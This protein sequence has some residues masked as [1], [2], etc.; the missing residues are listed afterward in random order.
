[1]PEHFGKTHFCAR[2][3]ENIP[4]YNTAN[5][6]HKNMHVH[7]I[8]IGGS[9][10]H[11]L[12]IA[13]KN[14]GVHVTGSDDAIFE[15]SATRL[16]NAD[17]LPAQMGW[18]PDKISETTS[19][20]IL[21]MHARADNPEL[22]KANEL[23]VRVYSFPEYFYENTKNKIRIVVA[24]SHGK[25]STTA[26]LMHVFNHAGKKFDYLVGSKVDGFDHMVSLSPDSEYAIIEGDEYLT[27]P[28]DRRP[29]FV[30]YRANIG[31]LNGIAWDHIN[32][33]PTWDEYLQV[34]KDFIETIALGGRLFYFKNDANID[35]VLSKVKCLCLP[36][37]YSAFPN[38]INNGVT[39]LLAGEK[40][41]PLRVFGE[42]NMQNMAATKKVCDSVGIPEILFYTAMESFSG[43]GRR[44]ELIRSTPHTSIFYDFAHSPSKLKATVS[45]VKKQF[46]DR[47]LVALFELHTFSSLNADFLK[48]YEGTLDDADVA[49]VYFNPDEIAHK[50]LTQF[51]EADVLSAF[52]NK[53]LLVFTQA[54]AWQKHIHMLSLEDVSLLLMSSGSF[55]GINIRDFASSL[56]VV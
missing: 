39:Y 35:S 42:H 14:S 32:V 38:V 47:K 18:F 43:A 44:L 46:A 50:K 24:G 56:Q 12:A 1:M 25:T 21:G 9:I 45:A 5:I 4:K 55:G 2:F 31:I 30:H 36:E 13:M 10:M 29:K 54:D 48:E 19:S 22:I 41:Y 52:A 51:D 34:F 27:S 37:S 6:I 11:S 49:M 33:F 7:F 3:G 26:M 40:R 16:K 23:G 15:P 28:I 53:N 20:V 8:A 17:L